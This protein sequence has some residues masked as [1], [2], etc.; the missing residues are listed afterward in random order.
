MSTGRVL[1][2]IQSEVTQS[3]DGQR[4]EGK[5]FASEEQFI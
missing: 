1:I 2:I 3:D 4:V 5:L